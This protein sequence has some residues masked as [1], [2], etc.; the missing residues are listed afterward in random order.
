MSSTANT[1]CVNLVVQHVGKVSPLMR[2]VIAVLCSSGIPAHFIAAFVY[3]LLYGEDDGGGGSGRK[4]EIRRAIGEAI[5]NL[6][7]AAFRDALEQLH[8][9]Q[10]HE[11]LWLDIE[12]WVFERYGRSDYANRVIVALRSH[13]PPFTSLEEAIDWAEAWITQNPPPQGPVSGRKRSGPR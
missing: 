11:Q 9:H 8:Q 4:T 3:E 1:T 13:R 12:G 10:V 2:T 5:R 6:D 7:L